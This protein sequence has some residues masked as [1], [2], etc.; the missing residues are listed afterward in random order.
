MEELIARLRALIRRAAGQA[1]PVITIGAVRLDTRRMSLSEH[2]VPVRLSPQEYRLLSY[3][4]IHA[5]R[6]LTLFERHVERRIGEEMIGQLNQLAAG[7]RLD[8][9][10]AIGLEHEPLD[11]DF[12]QPM[13][14]RYWQIDAPGQPGVLR[15]RSLWDQLIALPE[16]VLESG[17]VHAHQLPGPDEQELLVRE[18]RIQLDTGDGPTVLRLLV[19]R[20]RA[21]LTAAR[22]AF[23]SDMWLYVALMMLVLLAATLAQIHIGLA[24]LESVRRG[25]EAIRSGRARHLPDRYP[26][27]V[28]PLVAE[29]NALLDARAQALERARAWTADLAHGLKTPLSALAGDAQRL[30]ARGEPELA[31]DLEQL[32]DAMRRRVERELVRA[33]VRSGT[34]PH[35]AR[36]D[37][38]DAIAR[39]LRTLNRTPDG[40][41]VNWQ[42]TAP[43]HA[44][45]AIMPDDLFELLGNLLE[46]AAAWASTSVWL[47]VAR[48]G[49]WI[50]IQVRDD[51]PG[52]PET[53]RHRLGQRGMRLDQHRNQQGSQPQDR[54]SGR[55]RMRNSEGSGLGGSRLSAMCWTA[56]AASWRST[57]HP[58][59][60]FWCGCTCWHSRETQ[61]LFSLSFSAPAYQARIESSGWPHVQPLH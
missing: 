12:A 58:R 5:G 39:L 59:V 48:D 36:A 45:A 54:L 51:G 30:R 52:V 56:T 23:A 28:S 4:I 55:Q 46:N 29:L 49:N 2:G 34:I 27:E 10:G 9:D 60:A 7:L 16:D 25:V 8:A 42:V 11:P 53:Q 26:E 21:E 17:R 35:Q 13:S 15:S 44:I 57:E 61:T 33:R 31:A 40:E 24:P 3:L 37:V 20:N 41:Q 1:A 14:G 50:V 43:T 32:A 18:R 22:R 19:A 38:V 47:Q 6:L